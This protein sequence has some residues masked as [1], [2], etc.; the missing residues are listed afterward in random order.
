[1]ELIIHSIYAD[2][3]LGN[4]YIA[5]VKLLKLVS[6]NDGILLDKLLVKDASFLVNCLDGFVGKKSFYTSSP[7]FRQLFSYQSITEYAKMD[8]GI[9]DN[10]P[11]LDVESVEFISRTVR[12]CKLRL[13]L[14]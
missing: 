6:E 10:L 8:A 1:M 5:A 2:L 3:L 11:S 4:H 9:V 14:F 7:A 13:T 12:G